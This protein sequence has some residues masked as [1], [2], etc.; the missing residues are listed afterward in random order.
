M[1]K[2]VQFTVRP[3]RLTLRTLLLALVARSQTPA[4][5][6]VEIRHVDLCSSVGC[7]IILC[8]GWNIG[9]GGMGSKKGQVVKGGKDRAKYR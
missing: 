2:I 3:S 7:R 8:R 5:A 9:G 6:E 1:N 4:G